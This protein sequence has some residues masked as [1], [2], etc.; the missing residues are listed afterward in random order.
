MGKG[1]ISEGDEFTDGEREGSLY[2]CVCVYRYTYKS[3]PGIPIGFS[4]LRE[5]SMVMVLEVYYT[6]AAGSIT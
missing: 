2:I 1:W 4:L 5:K 6:A 3:S